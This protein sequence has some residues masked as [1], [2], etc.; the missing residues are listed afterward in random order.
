VQ[1]ICLTVRKGNDAWHWQERFGHLHF[2]A[3]HQLG[4]ESMVRSMP[5]IQHPDQVCDTY[6]M[7]KQ[8]WRP[9]P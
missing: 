4:K 1:L 6:V 3:L 7:T 8:R 2:K 5:V 9:F